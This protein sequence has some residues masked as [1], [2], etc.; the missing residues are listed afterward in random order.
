MLQCYANKIK[1]QNLKLFKNKSV[2]LIIDGTT[3]WNQSL[4]E[5]AIYYPGVVRHFGLFEINPADAQNLKN[6]I[7]S[8]CQKLNK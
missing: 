3:S 7:D 6:V 1:E 4:Y 2:C 5:F 8:I